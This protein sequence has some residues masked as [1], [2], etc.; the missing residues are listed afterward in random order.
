MS[1]QN[2]EDQT[3]SEDSEKLV[4]S[5]TSGEL[6]VNWFLNASSNSVILRD[7]EDWLLDT[8]M[9]SRTIL[10]AQQRM[11][12]YVFNMIKDGSYLPNFQEEKMKNSSCHSIGSSCT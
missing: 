4:V 7:S 11:T 6:D 3:T 10:D 2:D 1:L 12:E 9:R 8:R 5:L